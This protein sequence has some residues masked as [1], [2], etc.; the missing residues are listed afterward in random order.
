M[1]SERAVAITLVVRRV[2]QQR[3]CAQPCL[4]AGYCLSDVCVCLA[5]STLF[6]SPYMNILKQHLSC[7]TLYLLQGS[8]FFSIIQLSLH[9]MDSW[10]RDRDTSLPIF[11]CYLLMKSH[12]NEFYSI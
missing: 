12:E 10:L 3:A 4:Q 7:C 5:L 1:R 8:N 6:V 11:N 9:Y 2:S